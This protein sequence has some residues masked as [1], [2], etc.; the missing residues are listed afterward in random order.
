MRK[1]ARAREQFIQA[2]VVPDN[3]AKLLR[4]SETGLGYDVIAVPNPEHGPM[5]WD[6]LKVLD[7]VD[8]QR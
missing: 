1:I 8:G 2:D 7:T 6:V 5:A 3:G 4:N